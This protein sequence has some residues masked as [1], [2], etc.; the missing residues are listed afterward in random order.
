[1]PGN[2]W[3]KESFEAAAGLKVSDVFWERWAVS[4][5]GCDGSGPLWDGIV[6]AAKDYQAVAMLQEQI[7]AS[8]KKQYLVL[9]ASA[10]AKDEATRKEFREKQVGPE[11]CRG[12][13]VAQQF[14]LDFV[15]AAREFQELEVKDNIVA[16]VNNLADILKERKASSMFS[17]GY[18]N[19]ESPQ[20]GVASELFRLA[21]DLL[22]PKEKNK[23]CLRVTHQQ[24][25]V[26]NADCSEDA[27]YGII[28]KKQKAGIGR[29]E[30]RGKSDDKIDICV[31]F[32]HPDEL[33]GACVLAA[34]EYKPDTRGE[35]IRKVQ[36]DMYASNIAIL[37]QKPCII[38]DIAGGKDV[39]R[40]EIS[41]NG[42]VEEEFS[43][44]SYGIRDNTSIFGHWC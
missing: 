4:L 38:V 35:M 23:H 30:T 2:T 40:W 37:H 36:A 11:P 14:Y 39:E 28:Q 42:F 29:G 1:M 16:A 6:M 7:L 34:I 20:S 12:G 32:V 26:S 33:L 44:A 8:Q 24:P 15:F 18:L 19:E 13:F 27:S 5:Q 31:W 41:A 21:I 43:N 10:A 9:G 17:N 3:T 22:E 25:L